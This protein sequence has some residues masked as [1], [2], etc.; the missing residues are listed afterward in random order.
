[1]TQVIYRAYYL[2]VILA[3][4]GCALESSVAQ[5]SPE[6]VRVGAILALSGDAAAMGQA[7]RN[8]FELG[9]SRLSPEIRERVTVRYEDDGLS[10]KNAVSAPKK[11]RE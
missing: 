10:P 5:E 6:R 11:I 4:F 2:F 8:G 7:F 3:T 1:M 9:L